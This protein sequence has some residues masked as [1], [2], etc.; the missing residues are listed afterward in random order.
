MSC[1]S[2]MAT[3]SAPAIS[4]FTVTNTSGPVRPSFTATDITSEVRVARSPMASFFRNCSLPPA[5]MRRGS[6]TGGRKPPRCGW[7]SSPS[8]LV[9]AASWKKIQCAPGGS[10]SPSFGFSSSR[11]SVAFQACTAQAARRSFTSWRLPTQPCSFSAS[12]LMRRTPCGWPRC[13]GR[14]RAPAS[15]WAFRHRRWRRGRRS[16]RCLPV[17]PPAPGAAPDGPPGRPRC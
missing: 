2:T 12:M 8:W 7:P 11:S 10:G 9:R 5:H 15:G 13:A 16:R 6:S 14:W 4:C 1:S 17:S 3:P